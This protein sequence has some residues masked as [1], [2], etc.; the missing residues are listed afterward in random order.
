MTISGK[1][2]IAGAFEHPTRKAPDKTVAQLH[3]E[4]ALGALDD[5]GLAIGDVDGYFCAADAPGLSPMVDY[6]NLRLRHFD[7]SDIGGG[8]YLAHVAHAAMAIAMGKCNVALITLAGRPRTESAAGMQLR[9]ALAAQPNNVW[10]A[11]FRPETVVMYA[12]CAARHMHEFGTTREQLAWIK[13][14]ASQHAQYN[15]HAMLRKPVSVEEVLSADMIADP[16]GRLDCC[17][18]SDGAGALVVVKPEIARTLKRPLV[19]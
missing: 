17:V 7:S 14:A 8:S 13:V 12:M 16:L 19:T 1:A 6:L 5:A 3:A 4:C 9:N 10:E 18:V 11:V 15:S 2:Y